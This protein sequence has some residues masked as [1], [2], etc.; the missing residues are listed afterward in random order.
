MHSRLFPKYSDTMVNYSG[1]F[2]LRDV[3]EF[4]ESH[5]GNTQIESHILGKQVDALT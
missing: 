4:L 3:T 1:D 2:S 5:M